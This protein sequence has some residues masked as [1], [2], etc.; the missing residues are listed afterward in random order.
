MGSLKGDDVLQILENLH[1]G[2]RIGGSAGYPYYVPLQLIV[3][4]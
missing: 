1:V 2:H 3:I 4:T